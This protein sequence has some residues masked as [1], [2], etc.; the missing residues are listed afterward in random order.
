MAEQTKRQQL[1]AHLAARAIQDPDFRERLLMPLVFEARLTIV[2]SGLPSG[3]AESVA[4]ERDARQVGLVLVV[5]RARAFSAGI[6]QRAAE[7]PEATRP[8]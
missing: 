2:E 3:R 7:R 6:A 8:R 4:I 1:E 5:N